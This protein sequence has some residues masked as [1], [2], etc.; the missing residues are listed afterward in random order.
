M[1]SIPDT[2]LG[3]S[4]YDN[5][6]T[7]LNICELIAVGVNKGAFSKS[8]SFRYWR[9]VI[10]RSYQTAEELIKRIRNTPGE[11]S[12][13]TYVELEKLAKKWVKKAAKT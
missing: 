1:R 4:E 2:P 11:G 7:W 3:K 8:V 12:P 6:R 13:H 5:V 10:P 9:D